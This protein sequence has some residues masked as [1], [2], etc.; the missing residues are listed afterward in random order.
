MGWP[1]L[2]LLVWDGI[3]SHSNML[4]GPC[5][6]LRAESAI[7][8]YPSEDD[9]APGREGVQ[10]PY[11]LVS[12]LEHADNHDCILC[13]LQV[14]PDID[15]SFRRCT[16]LERRMAPRSLGPLAHDLYHLRHLLLPYPDG[17]MRFLHPLE[18]GP[19][20]RMDMECHSRRCGHQHI[21]G[22]SASDRHLHEKP[23]SGHH[24]CQEV[25]LQQS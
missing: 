23:R 25:G 10:R 7:W 9:Y 22:N 11:P 5:S 15:V 8:T 24:R 20:G 17:L 21:Y 14:S 6:A 1:S 16:L 2:P 19:N 18:H 12:L 13:L 3:L 4:C